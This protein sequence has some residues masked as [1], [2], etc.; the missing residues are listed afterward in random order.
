MPGSSQPSRLAPGHA[1]GVPAASGRR[2]P[3]MRLPLDVPW[4]FSMQD[5]RKDEYFAFKGKTPLHSDIKIPIAKKK[6]ILKINS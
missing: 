2:P 5:S 1:P 4:V 3:H 6:M